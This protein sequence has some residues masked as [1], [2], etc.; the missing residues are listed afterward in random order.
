M[1]VGMFGRGRLN[2]VGILSLLGNPII[3]FQFYIDDTIIK[4]IT[5]ICNQD[6]ISA[7]NNQGIIF[8]Q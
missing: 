2:F 4:V 6:E 7:R 8:F 3:D 5:A 1:F